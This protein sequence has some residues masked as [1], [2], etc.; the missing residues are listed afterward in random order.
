M[1][2]EQNEN[3]YCKNCYYSRKKG[4]M[5]CHFN[6]PRVFVWATGKYADAPFIKNAVSSLWPVVK[7][8]DWCG[9]YKSIEDI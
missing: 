3:E 6:P 1:T 5:W 8:E 7:E 9:R 4:T 2:K